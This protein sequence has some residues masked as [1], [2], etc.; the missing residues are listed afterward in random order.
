MAVFEGI[1]IGT[2]I[3][4][5]SAIF[6]AAHSESSRC[7]WTQEEVSW[8]VLPRINSTK[9]VERPSEI[10]PRKRLFIGVYQTSE[11]NEN[12]SLAWIVLML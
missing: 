10:V 9:I 12:E 11:H 4:K 2:C 8:R 7:G 6:Y 3:F 1:N 5:A